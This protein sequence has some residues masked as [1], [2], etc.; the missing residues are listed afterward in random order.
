MTTTDQVFYTLLMWVLPGM[1]AVLAF[2][3]ALGVN[4]LIKMGKDI[5]EIKIAVNHV[6]TMHEGLE[7]R[8]ELLEDHINKK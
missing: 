4:A 7:K 8:V 6:T 2:I 3:G 1:L 5:G